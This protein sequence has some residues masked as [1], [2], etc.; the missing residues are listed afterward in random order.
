VRK[1]SA[2][3][4]KKE[5]VKC[6]VEFFGQK[7]LG[8]SGVFA[9]WAGLLCTMYTGHPDLVAKKALFDAAAAVWQEKRHFNTVRP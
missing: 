8:F 3:L 7:S 4:G 1:A 9:D 2:D 5:G 6:L